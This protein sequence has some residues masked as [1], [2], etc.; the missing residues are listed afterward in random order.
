MVIIITSLK[1][2]NVFKIFKSYCTV[3]KCKTQDG[4][5]TEKN[6]LTFLREE[7]CQKLVEVVD[8]V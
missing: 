2:T 4:I 3:S 1:E 7:I 8:F 6:C 5:L